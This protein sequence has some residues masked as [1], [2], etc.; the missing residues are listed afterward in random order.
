MEKRTNKHEWRRDIEVFPNRQLLCKDID[1]RQV[2]RVAWREMRS[3][4]GGP[5]TL[6]MRDHTLSERVQLRSEYCRD[7]ASAGFSTEGTYC[8]SIEKL[9]SWLH[10]K[11]ALRTSFTSEL[12]PPSL[13]HKRSRDL[14]SGWTSMRESRILA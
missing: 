6:W 12:L 3:K 13:F 14:L 11:T 4:V 10:R 5:N 2:R 9:N 1:A 8:I 7:G